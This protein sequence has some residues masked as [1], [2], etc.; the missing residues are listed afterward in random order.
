M[1]KVL[2]RDELIAVRKLLRRD[3]K[4]VVFTNGCFDILHRGHIEYLHSAKAMGDV[5]VV[6]VNTDA[7]VRILKG[8]NRPVVAEEDRA[9]VLAALADVDFVTLFAEETPIE[10]IR[11]IVPDVL[12]KGADWKVDE[13][14]GKEVVEAAGGVVKTISY[15]PNQSTTGILA[16]IRK[17]EMTD[18]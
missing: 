15:I 14:V 16:K 17:S 4:K 12:V 1:G 10:L 3:S 11:A 18:R 8:P 13:V 2:T 7:S 5:L 9:L 6:G